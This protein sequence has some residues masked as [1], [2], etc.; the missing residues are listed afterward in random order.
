MPDRA[1]GENFFFPDGGFAFQLINQPAAGGKGFGAMCGGDGYHH[2]GFA[3]FHPAQPVEQ[4]DAVDRPL[5]AA[6]QNQFTH[7]A[8]GQSFVSLVLQVLGGP[9]LMLVSHP[10]LKARQR[11][12]GGAGK[13]RAEAF[14]VQWAM[15]QFGEAGIIV[16]SK[17]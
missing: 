12:V 4:P 2:R 8:K 14:H 6:G 3:D 16:H 1:G 13:A 5:P 15:P 17:L 10:A 11:P 7:L 9:A